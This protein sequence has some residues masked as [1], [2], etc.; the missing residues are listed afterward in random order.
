[1]QFIKEMLVRARN[2]YLPSS[3]YMHMLKQFHLL[4]WARGSVAHM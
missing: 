3:G 1:M 2:K 4:L